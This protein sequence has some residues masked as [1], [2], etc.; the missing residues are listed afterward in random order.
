MKYRPGR[1]QLRWKKDI[2]I[3][4][5]GRYIMGADDVNEPAQDANCVQ[6]L[7]AGPLVAAWPRG[8]SKIM[9][10][11]PSS[12]YPHTL[13]V[14]VSMLGSTGSALPYLENH[15]SPVAVRAHYEYYEVCNMNKGTMVLEISCW[16]WRPGRDFQGGL[17]EDE[18]LIDLQG[19]TGRMLFDKGNPPTGTSFWKYVKVPDQKHPIPPGPPPGP[20]GQSGFG[21]ESL[22]PTRRDIYDR[23][24]CMRIWKRTLHL[25]PSSSYK[26]KVLIPR[27]WPV[28]QE[29]VT[30][31]NY[32]MKN[33]IDRC[34]RFKWHSLCGV[35]PVS[36]ETADPAATDI[37][38]E[39]MILAI[40]KC[41]K[42]SAT[43]Y[44]MEPSLQIRMDDADNYVVPVPPRGPNNRAT[45]FKIHKDA[46][47]VGGVPGQA[48]A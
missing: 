18:V 8:L 3:E 5:Y 37:H 4:E 13:A 9:T 17:L 11:D 45:V 23:Q 42:I 14:R 2:E 15:Q 26:F 34:L 35:V 1:Q 20:V 46:E 25:P 33:K 47:K 16:K 24:Y 36:V 40:R 30:A 22:F 41:I 44:F 48:N 10:Q 28:F 38:T 29:D 12:L 21:V 27:I 32:L 6:V 19:G 7:P 43:R 39:K 31:L